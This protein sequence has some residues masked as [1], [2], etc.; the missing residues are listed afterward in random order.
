[1]SGKIMDITG[2]RYGFLTVLGLDE[3]RISKAG[4]KRI[5]RKCLC[6]CGN[7]TSVYGGH[8]RSGHTKSCGKC[9]KFST[10]KDLTG[11]KFDKLTVIK[12]DSWYYY[13]NG[14]RDA[15]WLCKCDCGNTVVIRGNS[16][17]SSKFGHDCGCYNKQYRISD[18]D[19]LN[20]KFGNLTVIKR[21]PSIKVKNDELYKDMWLCKCDCGSYIEAR[22]SYLRYG[23]TNSC[24]C[25]YKNSGYERTLAEYFKDN[26]I[27]F[28][29]QKTFS[30]CLSDSNRLLL[31][32]FFVN[33]NGKQI[34]V[35]LHGGQHY[36]PVEYF[37]GLSAFIKRQRRDFIKELYAETNN[38]PLI[39]INCT[40]LK[41]SKVIDEF[42]KSLN[43]LN[44]SM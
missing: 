17:K 1:M 16:L 25:L 44:I 24:G 43:N 19:M 39:V 2:N 28:E 12:L 38:I 26:N 13:P 21:L 11:Q 14:C 36:K 30:D 32:D 35:E 29:S 22:G 42:L 8:L 7:I 27:E 3:P 31:F 10:F 18:E 34:L 9:D 20:T 37:G 40:D 6:D 41:H 33:I 4:N 5:M 23:K 15:R